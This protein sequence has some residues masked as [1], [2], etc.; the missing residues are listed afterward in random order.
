MHRESEARFSTA[1]RSQST[2]RFSDRGDQPM[3][4]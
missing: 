1:G 4:R 2:P 3:K